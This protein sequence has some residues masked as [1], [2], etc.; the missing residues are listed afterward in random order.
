MTKQ[1]YIEKYGEEAWEKHL[2]ATNKWKREHHA[3]NKELNNNWHKQHPIYNKNIGR[4]RPY[5][6]QYR[7]ANPQCECCFN[8][9]E[10]IHHIIPL[11]N[12]R[13][14]D[15]NDPLLMEDNLMA[16]CKDCHKKIHASMNNK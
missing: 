7:L 6:E 2:A 8:P 3:H 10:D 12:D 9:T 15:F 14:L 4:S 5:M 13:V 1:Q 11:P 16:V